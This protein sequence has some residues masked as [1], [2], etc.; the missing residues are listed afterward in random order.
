MRQIIDKNG[1]LQKFPSP[2]QSEGVAGANAFNKI[3]I[4]PMF[5]QAAKTA[6]ISES[7]MRAEILKGKLAV[8]RIGSKILVLE[9]DLE[10]Y[11]RGHYGIVQPFGASD[12][13][14]SRLTKEIS[15][16][17]LIVARRR[18]A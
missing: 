3:R 2:D 6:G 10:A 18:S 17:P 13:I 16:S 7:Q 1:L 14:P 9:K 11:L 15:E 8:I 4:S 5:R 12:A